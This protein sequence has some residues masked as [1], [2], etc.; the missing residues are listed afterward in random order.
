MT[1]QLASGTQ[2]NFSSAHRGGLEEVATGDLPLSRAAVEIDVG[3]L[4]ACCE[5]TGDEL[6]DAAD[7]LDWEAV[8]A[9]LTQKETTAED[10][11]DGPA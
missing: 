5:V 10:N 1:A 3:F 6:L 2:H 7:T 9:L 11:C 8:E 4:A